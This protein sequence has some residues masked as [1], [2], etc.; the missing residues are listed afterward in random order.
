MSQRAS[1]VFNLF[2][3]VD[4]QLHQ[5]KRKLA[6]RYLNQRSIDA[7][8]PVMI[9]Q[10]DVF[11]RV[12]AAHAGPVNMTTLTKYLTIDVMVHLLF[13]YPLNLQ[14]EPAH[15]HMAYSRASFFFNVAFQVPSIPNL[16]V[17]TL[18]SLWAMFSRKRYVQTLDELIR[19]RLSQGQHVKDELRF[20]SARTAVSEDDQEWIKDVRT[21]SIWH[22]LAGNFSTCAFQSPGTNA[23]LRTQ[24]ATRHQPSSAHYASI[25]CAIPTA[26]RGC[27]RRSAPHSPRIARFAVE[28]FSQAAHICAHVLMRP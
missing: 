24:E 6:G 28:C 9:E 20:L 22:I 2:N 5:H 23:N 27:V 10:I 13:K 19:S 17:W 1:G 3:T 25:C 26:T 14:T 18:Q 12:L 16:R 7:F 21:E 4:P 8:E 15:R 11:I